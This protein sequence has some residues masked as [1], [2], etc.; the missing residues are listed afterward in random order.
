M[1]SDTSG[2]ASQTSQWITF[3]PSPA[4]A[5][6]FSI[7]PGFFMSLYPSGTRANHGASRAI[8]LS[9]NYLQHF[10]DLD[11]PPLSWPKLA[12]CGVF[13]WMNRSLRTSLDFRRPPMRLPHGT[14]AAIG[15][16]HGTSLPV[17]CQQIPTLLPVKALAFWPKPLSCFCC[18]MKTIL[19]V[20]DNEDDVFVMKRACQRTGIPHALQVVM[21]GEAALEYLEGTGV[22]ADRTAYPL[23]QVIFLDIHLPYRD[24]HQ[25]LE[26]IRARPHFKNLPVVMLTSSDQREDID[27][28]YEL[29][30]TSYLKKVACLAEFGQGVRVILKYWL[31]LN[32]PAA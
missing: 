28:A 17:V 2:P 30:V 10:G 27:R 29:G 12:I 6:S 7:R 25:V 11:S 5:N 14:H 26:W 13:P 19:L 3:N 16:G 18:R 23:P 1:L 20:E 9:G 4:A 24:G 21:S 32:T 22:Y 15:L 31:E 8:I